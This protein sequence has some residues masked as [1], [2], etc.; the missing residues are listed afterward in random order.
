MSRPVAQNMPI[1][2]SSSLSVACLALCGFAVITQ[3]VQIQFKLMSLMLATLPCLLSPQ[4]FPRLPSIQSHK[5]WLLIFPFNFVVVSVVVIPLWLQI[6][7]VVGAKLAVSV[8]V[9]KRGCTDC[10]HHHRISSAP[11]SP[12][13]SQLPSKP[14]LQLHELQLEAPQPHH[15]HR[16]TPSPPSAS[17]SPCPPLP[18]T[19]SDDEEND[20]FSQKHFDSMISLSTRVNRA[21]SITSNAPDVTS[22]SSASSASSS[23]GCDSDALHVWRRSLHTCYISSTQ[24][25]RAVVIANSAVNIPTTQFQ[26]NWECDSTCIDHVAI[27]WFRCLPDRR[28][29]RTPIPNATQRTYV[30]NVDDIDH[31][32]EAELSPHL[33][34]GTVGTTCV[35]RE[36][37]R[38]S[39]ELTSVCEQS[40]I[41]KFNITTI[42]RISATQV[43]TIPSVL[44]ISHSGFRITTLFRVWAQS[45]FGNGFCVRLDTTQPKTCRIFVDMTSSAQC[46]GQ[47]VDIVAENTTA[48]DVIVYA[49]R[50]RSGHL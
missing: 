5:C 12:I 26:A 19:P 18:S 16:T 24:V 13:E 9:C 39:T 33:T 3:I 1:A 8:F 7:M 37:I 29:S 32:I 27:Q 23:V 31:V 48:R 49:M 21:L 22:T 20:L 40:N 11:K 38:A 35:V 17:P 36:R 34:D 28:S 25:T 41:L 43:Q 6:T 2:I 30:P 10:E 50:T 42:H 47:Y 45:S 4:S 46:S 44:A 15:H 14:Q